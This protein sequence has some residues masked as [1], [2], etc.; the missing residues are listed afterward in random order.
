MMTASDMNDYLN[1]YKTDGEEAPFWFHA[2]RAYSQIGSILCCGSSL[3]QERAAA[4]YSFH[5]LYPGVQEL[6]NKK[7]VRLNISRELMTDLIVR[8]YLDKQFEDVLG[9]QLSADLRTELR[10][11]LLDIVYPIYMSSK[12]QSS[13]EA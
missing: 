11:I 5:V 4:I 8:L 1:V 12:E 3:L 2:A 7:S 9:Q 10:H 13:A 6:I